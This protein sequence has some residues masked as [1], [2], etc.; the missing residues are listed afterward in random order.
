MVLTA[1]PTRYGIEFD[2]TTVL[3]FTVL[4][5]DNEDVP[6]DLQCEVL[7]TSPILWICASPTPPNAFFI[8]LPP[9]IKVVALTLENKVLSL[10]ITASTHRNKRNGKLAMGKR[11]AA[12]SL[13]TIS[14]TCFF[15]LRL[16]FLGAYST[17]QVFKEQ[18]LPTCQ[19][20][21]HTVIRKHH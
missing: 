20:R 13:H 3:L 4:L 10:K 11:P 6:K 14:V 12:G 8:I 16:L 9:V 5:A 21:V 17:V 1:S 7:P 15:A 19:F 18:L 2:V